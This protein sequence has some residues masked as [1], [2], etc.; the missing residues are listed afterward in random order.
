MG[1]GVGEW[2][3]GGGVGEW[4][5]GGEWWGSGERWDVV[6]EARASAEG[7]DKRR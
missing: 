4:G 6:E 1:W 2:G 3:V 5:V 7:Q